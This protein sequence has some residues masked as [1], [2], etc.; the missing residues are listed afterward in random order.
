MLCISTQ[1]YIMEAS[2][3]KGESVD[4]NIGTGSDPEQTHV[5]EDVI[6]SLVKFSEVISGSIVSIQDTIGKLLNAIGDQ[7]K[8][9]LQ[10]REDLNKLAAGNAD[11]Q[12][13]RAAD[14]TPAVTLASVLK[15]A[16]SLR[17]SAAYDRLL[18]KMENRKIALMS[19]E[20]TAIAPQKTQKDVD[21]AN[22]KSMLLEAARKHHAATNMDDS[23]T[24]A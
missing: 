3:A 23:V 21:L 16:D 11:A 9:I 7:E 17:E 5:P 24:D 18:E 12:A 15:D 14:D 10:L 4:A 1:Y 19:P 8:Q 20:A 2:D 22:V 6:A 13:T